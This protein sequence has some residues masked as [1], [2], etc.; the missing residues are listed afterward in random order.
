[1]FEIDGFEAAQEVGALRLLIEVDGD[2]LL[3]Q[4]VAQVLNGWSFTHT[5]LSHKEDGFAISEKKIK[6]KW[7]QGAHFFSDS[8]LA[9][10]RIWWKI[11]CKGVSIRC[12]VYLHVLMLSYL[13][14]DTFWWT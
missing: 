10:A 2:E 1:M 4:E 12:K 7:K 5:G 13:M 14:Q 9:E 3:A 11:S 8:K 6:L